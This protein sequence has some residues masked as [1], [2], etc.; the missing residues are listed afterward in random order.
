MDGFA[1]P[2]ER[3]ALPGVSVVVPVYGNAQCLPELV[4]RVRQALPGRALE[5]V[6]VNDASPDDASRVLPALDAIVVTHGV[7]RGHGAAVLSGLARASAPL[8]CV[9]DGDL[10]DPP[11]LLPELLAP[12]ER[13]EASV[14][15]SGRG[16]A[17]RLSSRLFRRV[18]R[19]VFPSLPAH[20]CLC[21]AIDARGREAVLS[22]ARESD[23]LIAVIGSLG[24]RTAM[25]P[26]RREERPQGRSAYTAL[27]R[28]R[29]AAKALVSVARWR[30]RMRPRA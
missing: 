20:A 11:E 22:V 10:Q 19:A 5:L 23:Y 24:L 12:L 7:R 25:I 27:R 6:F 18:L 8:A 17:R 13:G 21:F 14:V 15:F 9:L 4:S 2:E 3:R 30:L 16:G 26:G 1:T 29:Y 28:V